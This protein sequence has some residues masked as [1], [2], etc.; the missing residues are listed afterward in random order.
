MGRLVLPGVK[1]FY[2]A[3]SNL[4]SAVIDKTAKYMKETNRESPEADPS[5]FEHLI[6]DKGD[7][8]KQ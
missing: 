5:I 4:H 8:A 3:H 6:Y 2:K 7:N 1:N